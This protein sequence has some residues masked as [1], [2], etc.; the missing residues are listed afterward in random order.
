MIN[1]ILTYLSDYDDYIYDRFIK[2]LFETGYQGKLVIFT[3]NDQVKN[4][5][6]YDYN[7]E[8]IGSVSKFHIQVYRYYLY[9]EYILNNFVN[10]D[11]CL[12]TDSRDVLF[13]NN[14]ENY[15]L[16]INYD[17]YVFSEGKTNI[18]NNCQINKGWINNIENKIDRIDRIYPTSIFNN[19]K[20]NTIICSGTTI[21]NVK[22][23]TVYLSKMIE[24]IERYYNEDG[25][26]IVGLDQGFHNLILYHYGL[27]YIKMKLLYPEDD[28]LIF[29]IG[30]SVFQKKDNEKYLDSENNVINNSGQK[31]F[32][33]HQYD[34]FNKNILDKISDKWGYKYN[35]R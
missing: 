5:C 4:F 30:Q 18:L 12:I 1:T 27:K 31:C 22:G 23:M 10:I 8:I 2:R 3:K 6:K 25:G 34:R 26:I 15:K 9:Y 28:P 33:V 20:N 32:I 21:G 35:I 7:I 19:I 11:Y 16:D 29:T 13:Q 17:L 24:F 14:I